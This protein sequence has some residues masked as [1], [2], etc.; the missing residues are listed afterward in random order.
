MRELNAAGLKLP[1]I[2][3]SE[4]RWRRATPLSE[5]L[6]DPSCQYHVHSFAP[7]PAEDEDVLATADYGERFAAIVGSGNVFG[8]AVP[9]GEVL[10]DGLALLANFTRLCGR[11]AVPA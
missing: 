9:P 1:H 2:G 7:V 4:V 6:P 11:A 10:R 3:W 8:D 5:G